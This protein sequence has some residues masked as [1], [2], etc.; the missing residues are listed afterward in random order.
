MVGTLLF[1]ASVLFKYLELH[2]SCY[3]S[4]RRKKKSQ[5]DMRLAFT[6]RLWKTQWLCARL[7]S[8]CCCW[9]GRVEERNGVEGEHHT[10]QRL[11]G[12]QWA[13][14]RQ[15]QC[16][17]AFTETQRFPIS[18]SSLTHACIHIPLLWES[19]CHNTPYRPVWLT[20]WVTEWVLL[21]FM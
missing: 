9:W 15:G 19:Q 12:C 11:A 4:T 6:A 13:T 17:R 7:T 16:Q 21:R 20:E 5:N 18:M 2:R 3:P 8:G 1:S 10:S 14:E